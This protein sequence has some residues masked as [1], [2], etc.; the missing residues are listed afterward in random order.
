MLKYIGFYG[1]VWIRESVMLTFEGDLNHCLEGPRK[2]FF[3]RGA[4]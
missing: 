4:P 1:R 2:S 3:K